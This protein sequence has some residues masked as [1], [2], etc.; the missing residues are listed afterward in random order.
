[1]ARAAMSQTP[2]SASESDGALI[3]FYLLVLPVSFD[4]HEYASL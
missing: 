3:T 2:M 1:M 4:A